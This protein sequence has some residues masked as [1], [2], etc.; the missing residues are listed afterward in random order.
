MKKLFVDFSLNMLYVSF[1]TSF[2]DIRKHVADEG[3]VATFEA[4]ELR[5]A[6]QAGRLTRRIN[7]MISETLRSYGLGHVPIDP[8]DLPTNQYE[9]VR[10]YDAT[11]PVGK[12]IEA[13]H[14]PGEANDRLLKESIKGDAAR[15][16]AQIR[17]LVED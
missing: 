7:G 15:I 11:L 14:T 9:S 6:L 8:E 13:A 5:D 12:A 2:D 16:L 17:A 4:W 1:M 3:G 10:V